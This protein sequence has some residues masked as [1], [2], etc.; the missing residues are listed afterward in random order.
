MAFYI[1]WQNDATNQSLEIGQ[2]NTLPAAVAGIEHH[3]NWITTDPN[4]TCGS[5]ADSFLCLYAKSQV[6]SAPLFTL[7]CVRSVMLSG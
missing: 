6:N 4:Y 1:E 3:W 2:Y 7:Q 5:C